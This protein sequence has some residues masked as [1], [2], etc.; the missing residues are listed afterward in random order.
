VQGSDGYLYGLT[1]DNG[2]SIPPQIQKYLP[3]AVTVGTMFKV[4]TTGTN[5]TVLIPFFGIPLWDYMG[6]GIDP[7]STPTLHTNGIICKRP[8]NAPVR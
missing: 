4:S 5:Y 8:S 1:T 7:E 2:P 6:P 3:P